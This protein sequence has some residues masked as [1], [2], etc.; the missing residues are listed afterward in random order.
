MLPNTVNQLICNVK[1]LQNDFWGKYKEVLEIGYIK[2][3]C[4][5][6]NT[7]TKQS[8]VKQTSYEN[9]KNIARM[10]TEQRGYKRA[11]LQFEEV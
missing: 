1:F 3:I 6:I 11:A 9:E 5:Y 4:E 2:M 8:N 7:Q 10:L